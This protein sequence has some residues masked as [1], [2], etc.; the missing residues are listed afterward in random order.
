M[1]DTST[2]PEFAEGTLDLASDLWFCG[3][4]ET[5]IKVGQDCPFCKYEELGPAAFEKW[6]AKNLST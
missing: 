4:H 6:A 1:M 3:E 5:S 2:A